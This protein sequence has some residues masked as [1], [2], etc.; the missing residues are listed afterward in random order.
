MEDV[1]FVRKSLS[2]HIPDHVFDSSRVRSGVISSEHVYAS[3]WGF[4][5]G[6]PGRSVDYRHD[7]VD[8]HYSRCLRT[9]RGDTDIYPRL[10]IEVDGRVV[11]DQ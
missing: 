7:G 9:V 10:T 5:E 4:V 8:F 11:I 3:G 1:E 2:E 6:P